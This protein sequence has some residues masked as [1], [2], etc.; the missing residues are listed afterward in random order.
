MCSSDLG[1][2]IVAAFWGPA[3]FIREGGASSVPPSDPKLAELSGH[4]ASEDPW[5]G[6]VRVVERG[7]RLWLG[8]QT[9][10]QQ[11]G[12]NR[13]RIGNESWSPE[14]GSFADFADGRPETFIYSGEKFTR[15]AG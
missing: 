8:T 7:G 11:V 1:S 15:R 4:Y 5:F 2:A 12:D 10:M 14:R 9:P 3:T 6:S 13:W